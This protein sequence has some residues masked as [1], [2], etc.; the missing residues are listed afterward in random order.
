[1]Y[2]AFVGWTVIQGVLIVQCHQSMCIYVWVQIPDVKGILIA[3]HWLGGYLLPCHLESLDP[4]DG[5]TCSVH[6]TLSVLMCWLCRTPP[7]CAQ[8]LGCAA[9]QPH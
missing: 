9:Q 2:S 5:M 1:M 3:V 4:G 8:R 6:H 7:Q